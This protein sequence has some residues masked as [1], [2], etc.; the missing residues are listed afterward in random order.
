MEIFAGLFFTFCFIIKEMKIVIKYSC[1]YLCVLF[2]I[3][4]ENNIILLLNFVNIYNSN[5]VNII[6]FH[7]YLSITIFITLNL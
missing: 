1:Y 7:S 3:I 4:L 5:K 6:K 2:Y